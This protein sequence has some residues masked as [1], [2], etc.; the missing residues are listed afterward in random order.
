MEVDD[1]KDHEAKEEEDDDD[2]KNADVERRKIPRPGPTCIWT[3]HDRDPH[4]LWTF[5]K[6][7]FMGEFTGKMPQTKLADETL[8]GPAIKMHFDVP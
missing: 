8:W 2:V 5:H 6:S 4:A 1:V 7:H 3:F